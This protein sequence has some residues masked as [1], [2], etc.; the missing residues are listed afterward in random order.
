MNL[1]SVKPENTR[2]FD[3]SFIHPTMAKIQKEAGGLFGPLVDVVRAIVALCLP[4]MPEIPPEILP[5]ADVC[6]IS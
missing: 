2:L 5:L 4:G 3:H 6:Q 1:G